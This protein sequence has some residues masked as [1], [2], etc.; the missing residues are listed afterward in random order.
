LALVRLVPYTSDYLEKS[1]AWLNEPETKRLTMTPDFTREE[2]IAFFDG[3]PS[4][5]DYKIWGI[6]TE[7]GTPIGAAGIKHIDGGTGEVFLYIGEPSWRGRGAGSDVLR[8]CQE[9]ALQLGLD[10]LTATI[11][12]A[13]GQSVRAFEKAGYTI[14]ERGSTAD[15]IRMTKALV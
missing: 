9:R 11:L 3:L 1:W 13:N 8:L 2:Q 6:A 15:A 10:Q 5:D 7:E 4:R 14:D 12:P